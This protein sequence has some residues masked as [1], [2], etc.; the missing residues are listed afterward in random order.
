MSKVA[1]VGGGLFGSIT[2]RALRSRGHEVTMIDARLEEAGS[3]PAACLIKPSW[4]AGLGKEVVEQAMG[5]L[6][7]L[8][9]VKTIEFAVGPLKQDV[10]WID[11]L[12]ILS[13]QSERGFVKKVTDDG[14]VVSEHDGE[15][16]TRTFDHVVL[17]AGI[18]TDKLVPQGCG[19]SRVEPRD[20][21]AFLFPYARIDEPFIAPWAPYRQVVAFNRGDGLWISD[22]TALKPESLTEDRMADSMERCHLFLRE[23]AN[24]GKV[25]GN[26]DEFLRMRGSRPYVAKAKPCYFEMET[27][28]LTVITGGAKNGTLAAG[29]CASRIARF[30]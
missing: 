29:W 18:W 17:A 21:V 24:K 6:R 7:S 28:H 13:E 3:N 27:S 11:P 16:R 25:H 10:S 26:L 20:G 19:L 8:Y 9:N 30:A 15:L 23:R 22:G 14:M 4:V 5:E 2:T 1:V 12:T